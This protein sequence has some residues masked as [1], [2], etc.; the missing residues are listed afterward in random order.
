MCQSRT[1][2]VYIEDKINHKNCATLEY[3]NLVNN[4]EY[5]LKMSI[6]EGDLLNS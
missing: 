2:V 3:L 1:F 6:F 5:V 4:T